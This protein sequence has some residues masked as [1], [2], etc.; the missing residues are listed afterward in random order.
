L[1]RIGFSFAGVV[2]A[3]GVELEPWQH[4]AVSRDLLAEYPCGSTVRVTLP[5]EV[6]GRTSADLVVG[7]TMNPMHERTINIYVSQDEPAYQYG[8]LEGG[9]FEGQ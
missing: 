4:V 6:G 2:G 3:C 5:E 1:T 9:T 8:L 7:D